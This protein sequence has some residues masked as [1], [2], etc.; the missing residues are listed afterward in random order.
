MN[1]RGVTH[2]FKNKTAF[3]DLHALSLLKHMEDR[4]GI[5]KYHY[6]FT[7]GRS[8][9]TSLVAFYNGLTTSVAQGRAMDVASLV[10]PKAFDTV[11]HNLLLLKLEKD[12]MGVLFSGGGIG[13]MA[14]FRV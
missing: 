5:R 13:W 14:V 2:Q 8:C 11:I 4:E 3:K 1:C 6:G 10:F 12:L 7:K 9:S